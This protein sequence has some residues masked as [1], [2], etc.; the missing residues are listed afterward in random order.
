MAQEQKPP[1]PARGVRRIP[2]GSFLYARLIPLL[3]I[4][5]GIL[6]IVIV[7]FSFG[8]AFGLITVPQ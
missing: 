2:Q 4:V 1:R 6:L 8:L 5:F 7:L 3:L